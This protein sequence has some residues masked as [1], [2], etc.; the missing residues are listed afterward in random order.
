MVKVFAPKLSIG[1]KEILNNIEF[2]LDN[3]I[4]LIIGKNGSGKST[5][6]KYM[7]GLYKSIN[8]EVLYDG[9]SIF[10]NKKDIQLKTSALFVG[11][12]CY[13]DFSVIDNLKTFALYQNVIITNWDVYLTKFGLTEYKNIRYKNLS[14]GNCQK[15]NIALAFL[16]DPDVIYLDEPFLAIDK[17]AIN[18]IKQVLLNECKNK[19]I[20]IATHDFEELE[21]CY[22][23]VILTKKGSTVKAINMN[24]VEI[25]FGSLKNYF[26]SW[27]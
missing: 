22:S 2:N 9:V 4:V 6:I 8:G 19:T 24:H 25:E 1:N 16:N 18:D 27:Y 7:L 11:Q 15:T 23:E 12:K 20:V 3:G 10:T 13:P 17:H 21:D 14:S 26:D 5:L